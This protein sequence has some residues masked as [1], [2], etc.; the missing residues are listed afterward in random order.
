MITKILSFFQRYI[1]IALMLLMMVV[2]LVSAVELG[3]MIVLEL[4]QTPSMQL[5]VKGAL[6]LFGFF[7]IIL[8][9]L[10]LMHTIELYLKEEHL[11]VEIVFLVAMI[12]VSRKVIILDYKT[13]SPLMLL[14]IGSVILALAA[15]YY[16][17][18]RT[19]M[20]RPGTDQPKEHD[21]SADAP[22]KSP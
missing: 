15:G 5:S 7:F 12:A 6:E 17:V 16:L 9:G 13:T 4:I 14:G 18:R 11:H 10:E 3:I 20:H 21:D 2:I 8:I 22:R 19:S 1:V